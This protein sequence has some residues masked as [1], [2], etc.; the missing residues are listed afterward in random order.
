LVEF[1]VR[2][3]LSAPQFVIVHCGQIVVHQ[4]IAMDALERGASHQCVRS[5]HAKQACRFDDEKW[6]EPF[7][8]AEA[9]IA[10]GLNE[11]HRPRQFAGRGRGGQQ[12]IEQRLGFRRYRVEPRQKRAGFAA[13]FRGC[14]LSL[15]EALIIPSVLPWF[16]SEFL[17]QV[18]SFPA[19]EKRSFVAQ[20]IIA[21]IV[22]AIWFYLIAARGGFWRA[23]ERD[24]ALP[25]AL[26]PIPQPPRI[27]A[28]VPARDEAQ[29]VGGTI[30]SLLR[31]AYGGAVC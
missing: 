27:I 1:A 11:A 17:Y 15:A 4:R 21:A 19:G 3:R 8:A 6:A 20:D 9:R 30:T 13:H 12:P 14:P 10:H 18:L 16:P 29:T 23:A 28:V 7:A 5:R 22:L 31:P 25:A 26:R 2:G 24:D